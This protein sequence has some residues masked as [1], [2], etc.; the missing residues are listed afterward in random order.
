MVSASNLPKLAA[1]RSLTN[2]NILKIP[3]KNSRNTG[4][5]ILLSDLKQLLKWYEKNLG[6]EFGNNSYVVFNDWEKAVIIHGQL[7]FYCLN[8]L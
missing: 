1:K 7:V 8:K 6:I 3:K 5:V 4:P 2:L